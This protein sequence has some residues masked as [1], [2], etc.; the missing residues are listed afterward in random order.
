MKILIT[1][2][3]LH[4]FV[5]NSQGG[6]I[7]YANKLLFELNQGNPSENVQKISCENHMNIGNCRAFTG[8]LIR[9]KE[10]GQQFWICKSAA[11]CIQIFNT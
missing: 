5:K 4:H 11:Y 8:T 10:Q 9:K 1:V 6:H 2:G 3:H 7:G